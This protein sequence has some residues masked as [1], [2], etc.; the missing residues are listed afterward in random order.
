MGLTRTAINR[1]LATVMIFLAFI[2]LGQQAYTKMK[3]DRFPAITFPVVYVQINWPGATPENIEQAI[4]V[5]AENAVSGASGIQ[6]VDANAQQDWARLTIYFVDGTDV[7]QATLDVQR[8]LAAIGR[9]L[10][11]DATQPSVQKADPAAIPVLYIVLSG[12]LPPEE[13]YD[14]ASN[15]VQQQ[16]EAVPGVADVSISGGLIRE[17]QVQVDYTKL[18]AYGLSLQ[19]IVNTIQRENVDSPGGNVDVDPQTFSVRATGLAQTPA[20]IGEYV[21]ATSPG[22]VLLKDIAKVVMSTKRPTSQVRYTTQDH[23]AVDSVSLVV[24]KQTDANTLDTADAL[25]KAVQTMRRTLPPASRSRSPTTRR[26]SSS[27]PSTP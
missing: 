8:R 11:I 22:P 23:P 27:T 12:K 16:L 1:P 6:R 21:V 26:A 14:L 3:V 18:Q 9:L 25:R 13:L 24:T 17:I 2:L 19:Q 7:D 15:T 5:P 20:D 4:I 10:P